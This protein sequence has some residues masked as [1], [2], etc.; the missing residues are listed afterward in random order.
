MASVTAT[1]SKWRSPQFREHRRVPL[2]LSLPSSRYHPYLFTGFPKDC[3]LP[4]HQPQLEPACPQ[5]HSNLNMPSSLPW[6]ILLSLLRECNVLPSA[7]NHDTIHN[8]CCHTSMGDP[9]L[10]DT[11]GWFWYFH[12]AELRTRHFLQKYISDI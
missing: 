7:C 8:S 10:C 11:P 1:E 9:W 12:E 6:S 3:L 4:P 5:L 2:C